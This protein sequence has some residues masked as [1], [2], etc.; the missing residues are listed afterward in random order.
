MC[1]LCILIHTIV[2]HCDMG[3][4]LN[5]S[6]QALANWIKKLLNRGIELYKTLLWTQPIK[7]I[8]QYNFNEIRRI[9]SHDS[10]AWKLICQVDIMCRIMDCQPFCA[11]TRFP[12]AT[13]KLRP[14]YLGI[15]PG[16]RKP[17]FRQFLLTVEVA[18]VVVENIKR[19]W[20]PPTTSTTKSQNLLSAGRRRSPP[21]N[22]TKPRLGHV[23]PQMTGDHTWPNRG[24]VWPQMTGDHIPGDLRL[25]ATH[26]ILVLNLIL[27]FHR[28]SYD[29]HIWAYFQG[30]A[31]Q[32][33]GNF[34]WL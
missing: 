33:S 5:H 27:G 32:F 28:P 2:L 30:C 1:T 34:Y 31:S 29:H 8:G 14:P 11:Y 13:T 6:V 19:V 7:I 12:Q 3:Y 26:K 4:T 17:I 23:W 25:P 21:I 15:L 10:P 18:F 16:L 24:H 22:P 20:Y 9:E